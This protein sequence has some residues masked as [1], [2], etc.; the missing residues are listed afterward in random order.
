MADLFYGSTHIGTTVGL[1]ASSLTGACWI[2]WTFI[3]DSTGDTIGTASNII[4]TSDITWQTW[5]IGTTNITAVDDWTQRIL[6]AQQRAIAAA[7]RPV[8]PDL[9]HAE[10]LPHAEANDKAHALLQSVLSEQQ[11]A[12]L[13]AAGYFDVIARGSKRRYRIFRGSH[14]NVFALGEGGGYAMKYCGQPQN[15]PPD[16]ILLAQKLQIEYAEDEFLRLANPMRLAGAA[17]A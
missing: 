11:W 9:L 10:R 6:D 2:K 16:D 7:P 3:G 17:A 1:D 15:L 4:S 13:K 5:T 8:A 14:G 12:P